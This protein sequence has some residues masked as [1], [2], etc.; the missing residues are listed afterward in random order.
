MQRV[1][2]SGIQPTGIPHLGNYL[3]ALSNWIRIQNTSPPSTRIYYSVVGLHALTVPQDPTELRREKKDMLASLLALGIDPQRVTLFQQDQVPQHSELAWIFNCLTPVGWLNRMTSWKA[4]LAQLR[5][6]NSEEEVNDSLLG[7][8]LLGYPVLQAADILLYGATEVPVG[9]DQKQHLE[10]TRDLAQLFNRTYKTKT[11]FPPKMLPTNFPKVL[12]LR[13]PSQKMSKSAP[14]ATSRI[15]LLDDPST[16]QSKFRTAVTDSLGTVTYDPASRPGVSNLISIY[17]SFL[18]RTPEDVGQEL[19]AQGADAP[20]LKS[21]VTEAVS[22]G[23]ADFRREYQRIRADAAYLSEVEET[24]KK[25]ASH[26]ARER[27]E[28]VKRVVGLE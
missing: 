28:V 2:F 13:D 12:S 10:L 5:Q 24:G 9:E 19:S 26:V 1:V 3:G 22:E 15:S 20:K 18:R 25:E 27:M 4:K 7:M 11:F 17:A 6:S 16:I 21:L 8:G 14:Q 23:L